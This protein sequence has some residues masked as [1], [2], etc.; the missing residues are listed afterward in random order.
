MIKCIIFDL[1]GTLVKSHETIYKTTIKALEELNINKELKELEELYLDELKPYNE[2][3][4]NKRP[5]SWG[6]I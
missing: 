1:D 4:Y 6:D 3:G 5:K 2:K